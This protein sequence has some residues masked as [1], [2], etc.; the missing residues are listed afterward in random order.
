MQ[1]QTAAK[2]GGYESLCV[3]VIH[4]YVWRSWKYWLRSRIGTDWGCKRK[5]RG[6]SQELQWGNACSL[7]TDCSHCGEQ[8][9]CPL[10]PLGPDGFI[11]VNWLWTVFSPRFGIL[12]HTT[13]SQGISVM[14]T[15]ILQGSTNSTVGAKWLW[16]SHSGNKRGTECFMWSERGGSRL[17][18]RR[19]TWTLSGPWA[20][21]SAFLS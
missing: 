5:K 18:P 20:G 17:W 16:D 10:F 15:I 6:K 3:C 19:S 12:L 7:T 2:G 11:L 13:T 1:P 14:K 4:A 8:G 21:A 9:T